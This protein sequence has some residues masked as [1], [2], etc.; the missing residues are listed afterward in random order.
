MKMSKS[1][2][3]SAI[4]MTDGEEEVKKKINNAFC[5][6]GETEF[7]P[8]IDWARYIVFV[9]DKV[10]LEV[11]RLDKFGGNKTYSSFEELTEDFKN[12]KLHPLDLKNA[13]TEKINKI[14]EPARK[15]FSTP[16]MAKLREEMDK[17]MITR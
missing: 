13:M 10:K 15:H 17:L 16:K 6:E 2:P 8:L 9:S 12:K 14:L 5:P 3:G 11:K 7:N 1:I 4:Y